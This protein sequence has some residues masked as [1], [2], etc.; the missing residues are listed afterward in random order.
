MGIKPKIVNRK[1]KKCNACLKRCNFNAITIG[2]KSF[3]DHKKCVGCSA[4]VPA[5]PH[6]AI[7]I[8]EIKGIFRALFQQNTFREKVV[9]YALAAQKG[10]RN[11]YVNFLMTIT[12]GCDCEPRKM[13]PIMD[14]IGVLVSTDPVAI[15]KACYDLVAKK[16]KRFKGHEQFAYAKEIGL[17]NVEYE[18]IE[19]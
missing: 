18:L 8:F 14:D 16:G 6:K 11:I 9:E 7:S 13:K 19:K 15:D 5:C 2:E 1:C 17:G 12:P 10:K 4:C 3:I